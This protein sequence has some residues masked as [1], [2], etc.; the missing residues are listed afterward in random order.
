VFEQLGML[1]GQGFA[2]GLMKAS[3]TVTIAGAGM[4]GM[5]MGGVVNNSHVTNNLTVYSNS[6]TSSVLSD[7]GRMR[8]WARA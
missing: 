8:A 4:A 2:L 5:A 3:G 7:F 1:S 6:E